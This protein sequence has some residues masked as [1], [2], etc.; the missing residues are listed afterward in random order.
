MLSYLF[1]FLKENYFIQMYFT[2][3]M[4]LSLLMFTSPPKLMQVL[5]TFEF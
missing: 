1:F 2:V 5:G 4:A 3:N